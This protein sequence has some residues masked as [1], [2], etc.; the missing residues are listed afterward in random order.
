MKRRIGILFVGLLSALSC[1]GAAPQAPQQAQAQAQALKPYLVPYPVTRLEWDLVQFNLLWQGAF[2]AEVNYVSS[3]PVLF[4]AKNMRFRATFTVQEKRVHNDPEP[5]FGL[6]RPKRESI[7]RGAIDH[8]LNLLSQTFPEVKGDPSLLY[9]E[10]W[11]RAA[12]G[13]TVLARF[14]SGQLRISE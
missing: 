9:V 5:F 4:D 12:G 11:Y 2:A 7:L 3:H 6:P 10:F 8:L 1:G 14:E 13:N